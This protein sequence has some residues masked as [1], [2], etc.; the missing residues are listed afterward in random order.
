MKGQNL[1]NTVM[2]SFRNANNFCGLVVLFCLIAVDL[3]TATPVRYNFLT[4][5]K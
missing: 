3:A 4:C 1:Y 2:L 5:A